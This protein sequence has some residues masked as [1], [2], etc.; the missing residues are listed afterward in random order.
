MDSAP[1]QQRSWAEIDLGVLRSNVRLCN[2]LAG[3]GC[4]VM[5]IVKANAYGHGLIE[6]VAA[7]AKE[8]D[9]FGVANLEEALEVRNA[10]T[11]KSPHIFI[12]SP[13]TPDERVLAIASGFSIPVSNAEE[14][15]A[16][17]QAATSAGKLAM[18][19]LAVDTGMGRM[20]SSLSD[21]PE[22]RK[23][24]ENA[25][26]CKLEGVWTHLPSADEDVEFTSKQIAEFR[27][28][29]G[30]SDIDDCH[31]HIANSAGLLGF[32]DK[33]DFSTLARIG[34]AIYGVSSLPNKR[35]DLCPALTWKTRVTLVR[36]I[37]AGAS[38]SYGRS[39]ISNT[40]MTT[41]TLAVGYGD[42]YLRNL[43]NRKTD[44]LI[45]GVRCPIL[46]RVTM[47]QIVVDVSHL[48]G[49]IAVEDEVVLI[50]AQGDEIISATELAEKAGTIAWEIF[51]G[52]GTRVERFY[53]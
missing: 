27:N 36:N 40:P 14:I 13:L 29:V 48:N 16:F 24:I 51:T 32:H 26:H 44:V 34:L 4:E 25:S 12:L 3:Q 7:L 35:I 49:K 45:A 41:A 17:E 37:P 23:R 28:F 43:S 38:V 8:V 2:D 20:G 33:L 46:G 22:L 31:I 39:F 42:G 11:E 6:V 1:K 15:V 52:I 53:K 19:H 47:D 18:L 5:A 9:W 21:F 10:A 50:G 30:D